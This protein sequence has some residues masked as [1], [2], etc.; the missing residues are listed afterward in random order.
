MIASKLDRYKHQL[1]CTMLQHLSLSPSIPIAN[2]DLSLA[3]PLFPTLKM[4]SAAEANPTSTSVPS[5]IPA[6][7]MTDIAPVLN[8]AP[9]VRIKQQYKVHMVVNISSQPCPG[10]LAQLIQ[11]YS[12]QQLGQEAKTEDTLKSEVIYRFN[13]FLWQK[14]KGVALR[15]PRLIGDYVLA[16]DV[17][18]TEFERERFCLDRTLPR[19]LG[20]I[21][22]SEHVRL[23]WI[24]DS[25]SS[26]PEL[27]EVQLNPNMPLWVYTKPAVFLFYMGSKVGVQVVPS[28]HLEILPR[29]LHRA[30]FLLKPSYLKHTSTDSR[31]LPW[32]KGWPDLL[33]DRVVQSRGSVPNF[34]I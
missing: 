24:F 30:L 17:E 2:S 10:S 15:L 4:D 9:E 33:H 27:P 21:R 32:G 14:K 8:F 31:L 19:A 18:W 11:I 23:V 1:S 25:R 28:E 7:T 12:S 13:K 3:D 22:P 6:M 16:C 34:D 20:Q 26:A 29:E 5:I